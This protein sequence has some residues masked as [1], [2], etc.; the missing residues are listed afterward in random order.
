MDY[1]PP[2]CR[3][4]TQ[5]WIDSTDFYCSQSFRLQHRAQVEKYLNESLTLFGRGSF[6]SQ[7]CRFLQTRDTNHST[8][9]K[10]RPV[11]CWDLQQ[12]HSNNSLQLESTVLIGPIR[13]LVQPPGVLLAV[14]RRHQLCTC[15]VDM[16]HISS[17]SE[18]LWK[19]A[20]YPWFADFYSA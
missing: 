13:W 18:T 16:K 10:R 5:D 12:Q 3:W 7:H 14:Y 20:M 4:L 1:L 17:W 9:M 6:Q 2:S 15:S 8:L 19:Q 11:T